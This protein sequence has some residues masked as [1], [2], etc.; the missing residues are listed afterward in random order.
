MSADLN[1]RGSDIVHLDWLKKLGIVSWQGMD[2]LDLGCGSGFVCEE[3]IRNRA[4]AVCGLDFVTPEFFSPQS[5]WKF[6]SQDLDASDWYAKLPE[7]KYDIIL[8]FDILEHVASPYLFLKACAELMKKNSKLIITTPNLGSWER[9]A[10]PNGWSGVTDEQ[11]KV[12]FTRYSL[13]FLLSKVG[14][15]VEQIAAPMRSLAFLGPIQ[16]HIGGQILCKANLS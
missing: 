9:L 12:L 1:P 11:H 14:L 13:S 7:S 10:N 5:K 6:V 8:A 3:A 15:A 2:V 4:K 16:P